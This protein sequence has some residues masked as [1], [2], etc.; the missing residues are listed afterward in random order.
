MS[1]TLHFHWPW[2]VMITCMI[3]IWIVSFFE[4]KKRRGGGAYY[5]KIYTDLCQIT[6]IIFSVLSWIIWALINL[7][8]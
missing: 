3:V 7:F 6:T 2:A 1:I 5:G 4:T 8:H